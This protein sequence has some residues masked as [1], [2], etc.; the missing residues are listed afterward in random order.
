MNV[1]LQIGLFFIVFL[2]NYL[3]IG[4]PANNNCMGAQQVC[5]G[6]SQ[7]GNNID[8]SADNWTST[9]H[10]TNNTIWYKFTTNSQGGDVAVNI[11]SVCATGAEVSGTLIASL[12]GCNPAD[13][14]EIDCNGGTQGS[15]TFNGT[16]LDAQT[17][18]YIVLNSVSAGQPS[19]C[20]FEISV[21]GPGVE[22]SA[23]S[24]VEH[25]I[26]FQ[27]KGAVKVDSVSMG[28]GPYT[29][30]I[31]NGTPQNGNS[32]TD[33]NV[34]TQTVT[35][36][37]AVGCSYDESFYVSDLENNLAI[38]AGEDRTII[39]GGSVQLYADGNGE[40]YFWDPSNGLSEV[41]S[42]STVASPSGTT[43][44][45]AYT[46]SP[47]L[48]QAVDYITVFVLP[49]III[50]NAFTPNGDGVNDTWQIHFINQYP[51]CIVEIYNRWGQKV[52]K[53][54]GYEES[55]EWTGKS[56]GTDLPAS[57]YYYV[58]DLNARTDD[59]AAELYRGSITIIK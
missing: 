9:C 31:N 48:C 1:L 33:L 59:R 49:R 5:Y 54:K 47:E 30:S 15:V 6:Q 19:S 39:E 4:Q 57:T 22:H 10:P 46:Y 8:A 16:A 25:A 24:E 44:Y 43:S 50:P 35:I 34:G 32:F 40:S 51:E 7:S 38:D 2:F 12:S 27:K 18:Y 55:Q 53:S 42:Q 29:Y 17:T 28:P 52:F 20:D 23:N 45:A 14:T 3:A 21:T 56:M 36:T 13:Y 37:D 41:S 26:C 11:G 58:I